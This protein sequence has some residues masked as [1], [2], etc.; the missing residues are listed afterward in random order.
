MK[1]K[2]IIALVLT[3]AILV[4]AFSFVASAI[5]PEDCSHDCSVKVVT[6]EPTC[7]TEGQARYHCSICGEDE[8]ITYYLNTIH[9]GIEYDVENDNDNNN[10]YT[11][12]TPA[13]CVDEGL[14]DYY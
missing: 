2:K 7:T 5:N 9:E 11:A 13:T 10:Y 1:A 6:V 4:T 8:G 12:T 14:I 3:A